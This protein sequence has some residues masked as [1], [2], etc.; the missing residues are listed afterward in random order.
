MNSFKK[1]T[2]NIYGETGKQWLSNLPKIIETLTAQWHLSEL[3]PVTNLSYNYVLAGFQTTQPIILKLSLDVARLAQETTALKA[4]EIM[5]P[6]TCS[7]SKKAPYCLNKLSPR[8][9]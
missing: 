6:L 4:F 2:I 8:T 1:N 5:V 9:L 3:K 7:H